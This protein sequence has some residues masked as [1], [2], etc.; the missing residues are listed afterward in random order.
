MTGRDLIP[1]T[2]AR[3]LDRARTAGIASLKG[4]VSAT[5]PAGSDGRDERLE[6]ADS[7]RQ[8]WVLGAKAGRRAGYDDPGRRS[9][10]CLTLAKSPPPKAWRTSWRTWRTI[11]FADYDVEEIEDTNDPLRDPQPLHLRHEPDFRTWRFIRP[12]AVHLPRPSCRNIVRQRVHL[13]PAES[14]RALVTLIERHA[15]GRLGAGR[16]PRGNRFLHEF[17]RRRASVSGTWRT[18]LGH[19]YH[20]EDF[21]QTLGVWGVGRR[22][23]PHAADPRP[24]ER[25]R[26]LGPRWSTSSSTHSSISPTP[27]TDKEEWRLYPA[28][29]LDGLDFR[30]PTTWKPSM[31]SNAMPWIFMPGLRSLY[32]QKREAEIRNDKSNALSDE[33]QLSERERYRLDSRFRLDRR[34]NALEAK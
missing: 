24:L 33:V 6:E 27:T 19:P 11:P 28:V 7:G 29:M 17:D 16:A 32:R 18:D 2:A 5:R 30:D 13:F 34:L 23:L 1:M 26:R 3:A 15:A 8:A 20:K 25:A 10:L 31:K 12:I 4:T 22:A 21:G 14:A 9:T